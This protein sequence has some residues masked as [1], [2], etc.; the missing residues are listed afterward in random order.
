MSWKDKI[1]ERYP[2]MVPLL[3]VPE[4]AN[5]LTLAVA[6]NWSPSQFR[7][8]FIASRWFRTQS[9]AGRR[10]WVTSATDPGEAKQMQ[11]NMAAQVRAA[12]Q[13]F[14]TRLSNPEIAWLARSIL[15]HGQEA[16]GPQLQAALAKM[17]NYK[18]RGRGAVAANRAKVQELYGSYLLTAPGSK[19][20][21]DI[22]LMDRHA[23]NIAAGTDTVE[24]LNER[25]RLQ[26]MKRYPWMADMLG[27]GMT[28]GDIVRPLQ[29]TIARE[30]EL[31]NPDQVDV[32]H[33][34]KY[35]RL[36][37]IHDPKTNKMRLMTETEAMK[38]ARAQPQW[39]QTSGG[40]QT[41]AQMTNQMMSKFG[42]RAI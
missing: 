2:D 16:S 34:P 37:G 22:H 35:R 10:Y 7:S 36:L 24:A 25:L 33:D 19:A 41:D 3:G 9:E 5:L 38:L 26:A 11:S 13:A 1:E 28:P 12:A 30:L 17:W 4:I 23:I 32:I 21:R 39:W 8:H 6:A 27:K 40:R 42:L 14:G 20:A 29:E 31:A 15:V 18:D